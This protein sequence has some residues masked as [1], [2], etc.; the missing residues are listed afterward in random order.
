ME[1]VQLECES[2]AARHAD[3]TAAAAAAAAATATAT[4]AAAAASTGNAS[5]TDRSPIDECEH[6]YETIAESTDV[7]EPIYSTPYEPG[8][9]NGKPPNVASRPPPTRND[10]SAASVDQRATSFYSGTNLVRTTVQSLPANRSTGS[11]DKRRNVGISRFERVDKTHEVEHWIRHSTVVVQQQQV[12]QNGKAKRSS[13]VKTPTSTS[14]IDPL[15]A[16]WKGTTST[17]ASSS[18]S[19]GD[20]AGR[21]PTKAS[22]SRSNSN[23]SSCRAAVVAAETEK[24][25]KS[26]WNRSRQNGPSSHRSSSGGSAG[27]PG[28]SSSAYNTG[29]GESCR[30]N[31]AKW[32][33]APPPL[34]LPP[35]P[36]TSSDVAPLQGSCHCCD[37]GHPDFMQSTLSLSISLSPHHDAGASSQHPAPVSG[38]LS[39]S[40][41]DRALQANLDTDGCSVFSGDSCRQCTGHRTNRYTLEPPK[42]L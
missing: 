11:A 35:P 1:T 40:T 18:S 24:E 19:G 33:M 9:V 6:I 37:K 13:S 31:G 7:E 30:S 21:A 26:T 12:E 34:P 5:V 4:T 16:N 42:T 23:G 29:T 36:P 3:R 14:T 22:A 32:S 39:I 8:L 27:E 28:D 38:S 2:I 17:K 10:R 41:A 15:G 25:K 20:S